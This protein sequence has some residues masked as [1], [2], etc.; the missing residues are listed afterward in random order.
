MKRL[1]V[2]SSFLV[3]LSGC[4]GTSGIQTTNEVHSSDSLVINHQTILDT[5]FVP[6]QS[7]D[8]SFKMDV[9]R[10]LGSLK[11]N[12]DQ[13]LSTTIYYDQT[14]DRLSIETKL[15]S[16]MHLYQYEVTQK[17]RYQNKDSS[18]VIIKTKSNP[19]ST[20]YYITL[21]AI[22]LIMGLALLIIKFLKS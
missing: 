20:G 11:F 16:I 7:I 17:D 4:K 12:N 8:T 15:D 19:L 13:G 22:I 5:V 6:S 3:L 2:L 18:R 14:G 10:T 9:L 1:I 21:G